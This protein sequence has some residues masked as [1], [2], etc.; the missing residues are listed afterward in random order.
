V[1][2]ERL[3]FDRHQHRRLQGLP[4]IGV[5]AGPPG[6]AAR[7]WRDWAASAGRAVAAV[8]EPA[9]GAVAVALCEMTAANR[10][11]LAEAARWV[12]RTASLGPPG[13]LTSRLRAMTPY[14]R[15]RWWAGLPVAGDA[16]PAARLCRWLLVDGPPAH[17]PADLCGPFASDPRPGV[18]LAA[19]LAGLLGVGAL[20]AVLVTA[21]GP[22]PFRAAVAALL[23]LAEAV[24]PLPVAVAAPTD[25]VDAFLVAAGDTRAAA[26]V[27]EGLVRVE[28]LT[29]AEVRARL[30]ATRQAVPDP[31]VR[32][33]TAVGASEAVADAL[34]AAAALPAP[35]ADPAAEDTSRSAAERLLREALA[36]DPE[37]AGLFTPNERLEFRH[38]RAAAE[39]DLVCRDLKLVIEL[40]G[41]YFHLTNLDA[42]RR[43][44]RKDWEY[45][46]HG[47]LVLR[48]LSEDVLPRLEE[49]LDTVRAAVALRRSATTPHG[50]SP[51]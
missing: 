45:Q 1:G 5:V 39:A 18:A 46:R 33:L 49:V 22:E 2:T 37:T 6:L 43:D 30:A 50:G 13:E 51:S 24:P 21:A 3:L 19:G 44:R 7:A 8:T 28:G 16:S 9:E 34:A 17:R 14:D 20:P 42:Y 25:A 12:A 31:V 26:A 38:G 40:D 11:L 27:R 32:R 23:P 35:P 36:D 48:F 29:E 10:S 41:A 47:Y 15:A 4:T